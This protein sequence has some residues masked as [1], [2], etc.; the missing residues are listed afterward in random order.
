MR[1]IRVRVRGLDEGVMMNWAG[2]QA[3][4]TPP[5]PITYQDITIDDG[6]NLPMNWP[7][8]REVPP[9][10]VWVGEVIDGELVETPEPQLT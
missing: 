9:G 8:M 10:Y 2:I 7:T 3:T 6:L 1:T 4:V 5:N